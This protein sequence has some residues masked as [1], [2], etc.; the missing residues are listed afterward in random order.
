MR[1]S[2]NGGVWTPLDEVEQVSLSASDPPS[3][4]AQTHGVTA[5][6]HGQGVIIRIVAKAVKRFLDWRDLENKAFIT[7]LSDAEDQRFRRG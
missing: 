3:L 2:K 5:N 1:F 6:E 4:N 7:P